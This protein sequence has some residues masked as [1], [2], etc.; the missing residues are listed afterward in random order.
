M[1]RIKTWKIRCVFIEKLRFL[2]FF[3]YPSCLHL[4]DNVM[5]ED[6][7]GRLNK[8]IKKVLFPFFLSSTKH[9]FSQTII[10]IH[11]PRVSWYIEWQNVGCIEMLGGSCKRV[12]GRFEKRWNGIVA[13]RKVRRRTWCV[14]RIVSLMADGVNDVDFSLIY[15]TKFECF[16]VWLYKRIYRE[17]FPRQKDSIS[18]YSSSLATF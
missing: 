15:T 4:P 5:L 12:D 16:L 18:K 13:E 6:Q 7:E 1:S 10:I 2:G 3:F 17:I 11:N 8:C 9:F 14:R